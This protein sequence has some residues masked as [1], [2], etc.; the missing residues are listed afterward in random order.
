MKILTASITALLIV[1]MQVSYSQNDFRL[2]FTGAYPHYYNYPVTSGFD[3]DYYNELNM[4][5]WQGWWLGENWHSNATVQVLQKLA[6]R[7]K[8]GFL[9]P[10]SIRW[11]GYGRVQ[12]NEA[13][14]DLNLRFRY[15]YHWCG[16]NYPD[17]TQWGSGQLVR[18]YD[19]NVICN[20]QSPAGVVLSG[21]RENGFQ[22][23]TGLPYDPMYQVPFPYNNYSIQPPV[24]EE[25]RY[26]NKY[27]VKPRMRIS[28]TDAFGPVKNVVKIVI[29]KF[30]GNPGPE[31]TIT[32]EDFRY[33]NSNTYDGRYLEDYFIHN[34]S[35]FADV[36]N[37][38]RP[39]N[40]VIHLNS[41]QVDYQIYWYGE[42]SVYIDY[43]KVMDEA[44]YMLFNEG[45]DGIRLRNKIQEKINHIKNNDSEGRFKGF[46]MEEIDYSNLACLE[47]LN[48]HLPAWS[49][50]DPD[51]KMIGLINPGS[52]SFTSL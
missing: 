20:E 1:L 49:N 39:S 13:E 45:Q 36:I 17:N 38:G 42:V 4:N 51:Y 47:Y 26:L 41:C 43:V 40:E 8:D 14:Y 27:Y 29:K 28:T 52:Y 46:Y 23:V 11:A 33:T 2:G 19:K 35:V 37:E 25:T 3:W 15:N 34:L 22:S 32:T 5:T 16:T 7:N 9:Q 24:Q 31:I 12:V 30:N 21:V 48:Q 44:A 18:Y 50:N 6:D 10:D